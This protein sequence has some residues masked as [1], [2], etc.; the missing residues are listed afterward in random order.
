MHNRRIDSPQALAA[1]LGLV[2]VQRQSGS[3]LTGRPHLSKA[4]P[5]RVRAPLYMAAIDAVR[6]K[7]TIKALYAPL[8]TAGTRRK[9]HR[10]GGG[11]EVLST[12]GG[13]FIKNINKN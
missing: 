5:A 8:L 9:A 1:Y 4:G 12:G 6:H 13:G 3:S 10:G 7:P 11:Q 2:P